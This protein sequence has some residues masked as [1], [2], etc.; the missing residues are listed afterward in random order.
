MTGNSHVDEAIP[1]EAGHIVVGW[2]LGIPIKEMAVEIVCEESR[3][4]LGNF[5]TKSVDPSDEQIAET[6]PDIIKRYALMISGGL[7]GNNFAGIPATDHSLQDDRRR[8]ARVTS[9]SLEDLAPSA[10]AIIQERR[11]IF[12]RLKSLIEQRFLKLMNDPARTTGRHV[13]LNE[14]ELGAVFD[15]P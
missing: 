11:R 6:P 7:A 13:L 15:K 10:R 4:Q 1:H 3:I 12:R 14:Q 5:I 2:T 9:L 8:L